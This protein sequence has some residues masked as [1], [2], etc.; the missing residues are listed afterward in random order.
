M[1]GSW[2]WL[3]VGEHLRTYRGHQLGEPGGM[4]APLSLSPEQGQAADLYRGTSA[5][6]SWPP[7][8]ETPS[9]PRSS[10]PMGSAC[11]AAQGAGEGAGREM[12]S[13]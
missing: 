12:V 10:L 4:V 6:L 2:V 1:S 9:Q 11:S 8:G 3:Q 7:K 13:P 5:P